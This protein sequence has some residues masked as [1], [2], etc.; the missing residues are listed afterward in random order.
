MEEL[1]SYLEPGHHKDRE[2]FVRKE[3]GTFN[4]ENGHFLCD[5]CYIKAGQPS[6]SSG[7]VCP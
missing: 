7:W 5:P 2:D 3:E 4:Q 6:S 1:D